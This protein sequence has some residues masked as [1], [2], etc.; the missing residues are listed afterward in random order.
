MRL[1]TGTWPSKREEMAYLILPKF[2]TRMVRRLPSFWIVNYG[3]WHFLKHETS[4]RKCLCGELI[5]S[6][7]DTEYSTLREVKAKDICVLCWPFGVGNNNDNQGVLP[8]FTSQG[9]KE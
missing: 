1:L 3:K 4:D 8:G 6:M 9:E 7:Y 5:S 2:S